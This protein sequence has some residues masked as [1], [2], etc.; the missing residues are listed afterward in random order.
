M[1]LSVVHACDCTYVLYLSVV[2]IYSLPVIVAMLITCVCDHVLFIVILYNNC[3]R[4]W[5]QL[6]A[7]TL[8]FFHD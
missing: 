3:A 7:I 1:A 6:L 8:Y 2:H 5:Q 4:Q